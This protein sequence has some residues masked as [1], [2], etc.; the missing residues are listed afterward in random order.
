L[1]PTP[2]SFPAGITT[3]PDGN[4]WFTEMGSGQIGELVL[5]DGGPG[6]TAAPSQSAG[7]AHAVR[8]AAVDALF[9]S[10]QADLPNPVG[11]NQQR[12]LAAVDAAFSTNRLEAGPTPKAQAVADTGMM[13]HQHQEERVEPAAAGLADPLAN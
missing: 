2:D 12:A 13:A 10:A 1:V 5:N 9:G 8:S 7:L 6:P 3:G 11:V 4:I